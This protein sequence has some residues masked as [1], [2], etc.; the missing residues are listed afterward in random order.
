MTFIL[1]IVIAY[2]AGAVTGTYV[3]GKIS[4]NLK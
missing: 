3:W 1:W 4:K 2:I